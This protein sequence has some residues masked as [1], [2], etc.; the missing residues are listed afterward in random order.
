MKKQKLSSSNSNPSTL[1][2]TRSGLW[3][4]IDKNLLHWS[5]VVF[6]V[7]I[8]V[9]PKFP[10]Q[11]VEYT[12]IR[13]RIDDILP[14]VMVAL[15]TI[16]W[17]RRKVT[18]NKTLLIPIVLFWTSVFISF[19]VAYYVSYT[20]PL[21][22]IG[23]LHSLRRVQYMI[24]FFVASSLITSEKRFYLY[25]KTY[26]ATF[27]LV[28]VYGLIQ[29]FG[30]LPSIQ[31]MNPAYVDGR[32]LWLNSS[33]RI[34]STF[35]GHFDLAAYITFTIPIVLGLYYTKFKKWYLLAFFASLTA[36]LYTAARSSFV[37]YIS[38]VTFLLLGLRRFKFY[39]FVLM[40]T[41]GLLMVTGDMTKRLLQTFQVRTVYTD[42]QTGE[43][44]IGQ[45][46]S[47][48]NLPAGS[49][50]IDLPFLKKPKST[51]VDEK[52]RSD[53]ARSIAYDKALRAGKVL[54]AK[55]IE[56]EA[57]LTT[58]FI[59]PEQTLLCDISCATRLQVEWPRAILA[60]KSNPLFGRGPS[61]ITEAT[62]NDYLRWLG[63]LGLV[64]TFLFV[65]IISRIIFMMVKFGKR[66]PE[67]KTLSFGFIC[68]VL[69]L[70]INALY[71]DVFEASKVA[72]HFWVMSGL[73]VGISTYHAKN[74]VK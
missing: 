25:L 23:L 13:I 11:F 32:L 19:L 67:Y 2:R 1:L 64:G 72:Y 31:S 47:V 52:D 17:I 30:F 8:A 61:S 57:A 50:E 74:K 5:F 56:A 41:A 3:N 62:D 63:E 73:F 42:E 46:I 58:K 10:I 43:T 20:V 65:F 59:K 37:A 34:N 53:V 68:G 15:F 40:V 44:R 48:K 28:S 22:N 71:I 24:V 12:Y 7:A 69:A 9:V 26:I 14:A 55:Q 51:K 60:F 70:L 38:A 66:V 36:L 4:W 45:E 54:T 35:G 18:L 6:I 29:K 16:Q 27:L 49:Y 21:F 33:D 39:L